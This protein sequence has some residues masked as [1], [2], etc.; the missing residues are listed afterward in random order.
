MDRSDPGRDEI[1][2]REEQEQRLGMKCKWSW[3]KRQWFVSSPLVAPRKMSKG[4]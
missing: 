3:R 2:F 4:D 1:P